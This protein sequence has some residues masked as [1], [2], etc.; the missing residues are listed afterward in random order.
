MYR[1][2]VGAGRTPEGAAALRY[3][4]EAVQDRD[5]YLHVVHAVDARERADLTMEPDLVVA[6]RASRDRI[7]AWALDVVSDHLGPDVAV[8]VSTLD[9][10]LTETLADEARGA[11][12]VVIGL[13]TDPR[14]AELVE[15]LVSRCTCPIVVVH[16]DGAATELTPV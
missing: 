10:P 12:M 9:G 8:L 11:R 4:A 1:I 2:V 6:R 5:T 13:P 16:A 7:Q 14:H 3:A 15:Q